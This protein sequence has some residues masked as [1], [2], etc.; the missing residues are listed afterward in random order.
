[1][2]EVNIKTLLTGG[3]RPHG[4]PPVDHHR[5]SLGLP[6]VSASH[7]HNFSSLCIIQYL[8]FSLFLL[9]NQIFSMWHC[10]KNSTLLSLETAVIF[11]CPFSVYRC[12]SSHIREQLSTEWADEGKASPDKIPSQVP[13]TSGSCHLPLHSYQTNPS[14][15]AWKAA[16]C[17]SPH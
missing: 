7:S 13:L 11:S 17:S 1:M 9:F 5:A 3:P 14:C 15:P 4:I 2:P 16:C 10:T 12:P 6:S 8:F